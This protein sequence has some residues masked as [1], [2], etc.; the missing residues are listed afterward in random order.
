MRLL[1]AALA[2]AALAGGAVLL[3]TRHG[4]S[5]AGTY[6]QIPS[7]LP[8]PKVQVGRVL[9]ATAAHPSFA[10]EGDSVSVQLPRGRTLATAVGPSVPEEGHFP[11]PEAT[12][13]VFT[14]TLTRISGYVPLRRAAFTTV[15]ERGRLHHLRVSMR[16]GR[17]VPAIARPGR[18]V[19]LVLKGVL[20]TGNGRLQWAPEGSKPI[21]SWDFDVEID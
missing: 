14:L 20:P 10:I 21:V 11:I 17:S 6:G 18:R 4:G 9:V 5:S 16:G 19:V 1:A 2:V 8:K 15:D 3:G 12:L 13:C 7:W